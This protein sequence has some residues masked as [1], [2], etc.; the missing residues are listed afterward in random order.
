MKIPQLLPHTY[1]T[2]VPLPPPLKISLSPPISRLYTSHALQLIALL[3]RSRKSFICPS[4]LFSN[5][6][7]FFFV[8]HLL[9]GS[10]HYLS[11]TPPPCRPNLLSLSLLHQPFS[12]PLSST[13]LS[14]LYFHS[15]L[16]N[17]RITALRLYASVHQSSC[18]LHS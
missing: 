18:S 15:T 3:W 2:S 6:P 5:T 11:P 13:A 16:G 4:P 8:F 1:I 10:V 7:C 17:T 14:V 12:E 9:P